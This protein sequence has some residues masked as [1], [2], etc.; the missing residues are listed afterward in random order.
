MKDKAIT[1]LNRIV[2]KE[3]YER[4][5]RFNDRHLGDV[6]FAEKPQGDHWSIIWAARN[7]LQELECFAAT[8]QKQRMDAAYQHCQTWFRDLD[9]VAKIIH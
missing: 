2:S 8:T 5:G 6:Y 9:N 3:R 4:I 7:E 1:L